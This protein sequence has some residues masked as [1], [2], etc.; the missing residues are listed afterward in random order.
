MRILI[1]CLLMAAM[2]GAAAAQY[3]PMA[4]VEVHPPDAEC[5]LVIHPDRPGRLH[6]PWGG[7]ISSVDVLLGQSPPNHWG[8]CW[9]EEPLLAADSITLIPHG[10]LPAGLMLVDE[11]LPLDG[12]PDAE[13]W[14]TVDLG[15]LRGGGHAE[16]PVRFR[17]SV[18]GYGDCVLN[19][20]TFTVTVR[21]ADINGDLLVDLSDIAYF[22]QALYGGYQPHA[23]LWPDGEI[24]IS[25]VV[26]MAQALFE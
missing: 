17:A 1:A 16:E 22:V 26:I 21:S 11:P 20:M 15:T 10:P 13:G 8:D 19:L 14:A 2:A 18:P 24:N 25:D 4:Y 7:T 9:F 5:V 23:D 3:P 6:W 12:P